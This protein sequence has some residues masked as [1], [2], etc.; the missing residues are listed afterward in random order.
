MHSRQRSSRQGFTLVELLV[1][2]AII[3]VLIALLL[4]AVQAAREAARRTQCA[5]NLKQLSLATHNYHDTLKGFPI[6]LGWQLAP[7]RNATFTDKVLLL[8]YI[9]L[10]NV[11]DQVIYQAQPYDSAGW[12]GNLNAPSQSITIP[13][14]I[15]PSAYTDTGRGFTL[16]TYASC[17]GTT[18]STL[19]G[20]SVDG[21]KLDGYASVSNNRPWDSGFNSPT[22]TFGKLRD[23]S[24][25][26][27]QFSE[28]LPDPGGD[29]DP[30]ANVRDWVS[31]NNPDECRTVCLN[32]SNPLDPGRQ[33][34]K[35]T[36]WAASWSA[37]GNSFTTTML[38]NEPSCHQRSG[39]TDWFM[40]NHIY[41]AASGHPAGV[42]SS[43]C[44]G[45]VTF[46]ANEISI[47]VWRALGTINNGETISSEDY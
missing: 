30:R 22:R 32:Q 33:G 18:P 36:S 26:T 8:P 25:N 47:E 10:S 16:N 39:Q 31:C 20:Q 23:G 9:E 7:D 19:V 35:G 44:D 2:I 34:L 17:I 40:G 12:G 45:S 3:G 43:L 1:V 13:G 38:P 4:P 41:A 11:Y 46:F 29:R 21:Y 15:C 5:N 14:F 24:S 27:L 42:N 6:N 37:F 28:N